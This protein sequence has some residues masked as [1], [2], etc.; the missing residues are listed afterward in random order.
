M[1]TIIVEFPKANNRT[2]FIGFTPNGSSMHFD[3]SSKKQFSIFNNDL[4]DFLLL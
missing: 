1:F 3:L 4:K 2:E